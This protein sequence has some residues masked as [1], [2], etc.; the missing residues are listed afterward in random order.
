VS[1][2]ISPKLADAFADAVLAYEAQ[3]LSE[4][5][6][7]VRVGHDYVSIYSVCDL[8]RRCF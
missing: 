8:S 3:S 4:S 1:Q 2:A 5:E 7:K 6:R